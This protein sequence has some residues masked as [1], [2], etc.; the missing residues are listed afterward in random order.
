MGK[1]GVAAGFAAV[2]V[3]GAA[4]AGCSFPGPHVQRAMDYY[5]RGDYP[6]AMDACR[7]AGEPKE[8]DRGGITGATPRTVTRYLVFCGLTRYHLGERAKAKELLTAGKEAFS[9]GEPIWLPQKVEAEM[10]DALE[11]LRKRP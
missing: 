5:D 4:L 11:D 8:V 7:D 6:H 9:K 1:I 10:N 3:A 2:L